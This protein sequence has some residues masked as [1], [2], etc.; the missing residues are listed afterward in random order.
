METLN[1]ESSLE[2]MLSAI[3]VMAQILGYILVNLLK[4]T[5]VPMPMLSPTQGSARD[6]GIVARLRNAFDTTGHID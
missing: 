5:L 6:S 1:Y 3:A 4:N 2:M